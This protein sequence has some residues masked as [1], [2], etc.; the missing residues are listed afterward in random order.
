MKPTEMEENLIIFTPNGF[1]KN[2]PQIHP[3]DSHMEFTGKNKVGNTMWAKLHGLIGQKQS[4]QFSVNLCKKI[5]CQY[6]MGR[7]GGKQVLALQFSFLKILET[8][9]SFRLL[10]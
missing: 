8:F 9:Q 1:I 10:F 4:K 5:F 6:H 3:R 2:L 7:W